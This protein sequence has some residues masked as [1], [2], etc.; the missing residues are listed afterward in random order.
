MI[1]PGPFKKLF[2]PLKVSRLE[3]K[4]RLVLSPMHTNFDL[5]NGDV[6]PLLISYYEE[7]ARGG[8]GLVMVQATGVDRCGQGLANQLM[9]EADHRIEGLSSLAERIKAAGAKAGIQL[10]HGGLR[11]DPVLT[12]MQPVGPSPTESV[13]GGVPGRGM[14]GEEIREFIEAMVSAAHR[15]CEAGFDLIEVHS[16]HGYLL[17]QFLSPLTNRRTDEFGGSPEGRAELMGRIVEAIKK[18]L[19]REFPVSCRLAAYE[20]TPGGIALDDVLVAARR[21]EAA[22]ADLLN[23]SC[24]LGE[25]CFSTMPLGTPYGS[26]VSFAQAVKKVVNVPVM[27]A[28][29]IKNP[30]LAEAILTEGQADLIGMGRALLADPHLPRKVGEG[31]WIDVRPCIGCNQCITHV[32]RKL[33]IVC[34]VN[35]G[36][37]REGEA[38]PSLKK[39]RKVLVA[40][41][42]PAGLNAALH[43]ALKGHQVILMEKERRLGGL[44]D[45]ASLP[46]HKEELRELREF[47]VEQIRQQRIQVE[48]GREVT[49]EVVKQVAPEFLIVATGAESLRPDIEGVDGPG[50]ITAVDLLR[51]GQV[52][53]QRYVILGGGLIGLETAD[54]ISERGARV[55]VVE[56]LPLVGQDMPPRV[57]VFLKKRIEAQGVR[58]EVQ[59]TLKKIETRSVVLVKPG[60]E[61]RL[62]ADQVV[63]AC[64]M[65]PRHNL[66]KA[67]NRSLPVFKNIYLIGDSIRPR[68]LL[69]A[70][71]EG[72]EVSELLD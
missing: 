62:E 66:I 1:N 8:V 36:L 56:R 16:A 65:R 25:T 49:P 38:R 3:L 30:V 47:L 40:G 48:L 23:I 52:S 34:T 33:P 51:R 70:M 14:S 19:G 63:L 43:C 29:R 15:A 12:K 6:T 45:I 9:L 7:R 72:Y 57:L 21:M 59:T 55:T 64:G 44:L 42:G 39:Q 2:E 50:V 71:R 22:G 18:S 67:L 17:N 61:E 31:R 10:Y 53:A 13:D 24:G 46:P 20:G 26:F 5:V 58:L 27:T 68:S 69:E 32:G 11:T 35:P 41:G 37:G 60:Q 28:G 54:Y 4:N